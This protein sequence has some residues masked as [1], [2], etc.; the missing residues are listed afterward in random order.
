[1]NSCRVFTRRLLFLAVAATGMIA[2]QSSFAQDDFADNWPNFRGPTFN[3]TSTTA[4]PPTEWS[5]TK[6][7]KWKVELPGSGNNSSPIVWGDKVFVLTSIPQPL[8]EEQKA[9]MEEQARQRDARRGGRR[10]GRRGRRMAAP[11]TPTKFVTICYDRNTGEKIWE[12]VAVEATPHQGT[13]PDHSYASASPV[14][15]G[16]HVYSHFG[17][18]GLYCYD[19]EGNQK[20]KRDDFGQMMTRNGFGE[21]SSPFLHKNTIVVPWDHEGESCVI[22]LDAKT[23]ETR[24]KNDR[25]EPS[26]WVTP[27]VVQQDDRSIVV[28]GGEN[29][30]RGYDLESGKE[31][32]KSSGFTMRPV[33]APVVH[34]DL[35]FLASGRRGYYLSAMKLDGLGDLNSNDGVAWSYQ[36]AAPDVPSMMLS[37]GR[38]YFLKGS[39]SVLNCLHAESGDEVYR[40]TRLPG[41]RGVYSSLVAAG[42]KVIVVGRDGAAVVLEDS[43]E[44]NVLAENKLDDAIDATPALVQNQMFLRGK[45]YLYCIEEE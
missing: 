16:Q 2:S 17:S 5:E 27:V 24:W 11:P 9:E 22:A 13:H 6:N 15:D 12:Q 7:I 32:W 38:V 33:S 23:G 8:T 44:F 4:T 37:N 28:T 26:N 1:M 34:D 39:E 14:T 21:G 45:K 41:I 19:M 35:V 43:D 10:G 30:A 42:G 36:T 40:Q 3:G 31:L 25:D 29:Y 20:W 18:R